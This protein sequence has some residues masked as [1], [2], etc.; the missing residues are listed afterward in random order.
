MLAV[1]K[2]QRLD[3]IKYGAIFNKFH[4][5]WHTVIFAL[6]TPQAESQGG[7]SNQV[8]LYNRSTLHT[9]KGSCNT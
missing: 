8:W 1:Q 2:S 7:V 4:R 9:V 5:E 3:P 6:C